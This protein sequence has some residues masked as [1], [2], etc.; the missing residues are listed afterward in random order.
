MLLTLCPAYLFEKNR[1]KEER[2]DRET[3]RA[4]DLILSFKSPT[5]CGCLRKQFKSY[6]GKS[7]AFE[8]VFLPKTYF[9][10]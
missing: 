5:V 6:S 10:A 2:G 7:A 9:R 4:T 1:A 3:E 8:W